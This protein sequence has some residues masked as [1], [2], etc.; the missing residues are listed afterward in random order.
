MQGF[1]DRKGPYL[2]VVEAWYGDF[3]YIHKV[4]GRHV[5]VDPDTGK[6]RR[7]C[8]ATEEVRAACQA[9]G[10]CPFVPKPAD[11]TKLDIGGAQLCGDDPTPYAAKSDTGL[12]VGYQCLTVTPD[13]WNELQSKPRP[14]AGERMRWMALRSGTTAAIRCDAALEQP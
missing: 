1:D 3:R 2:N 7:V 8:N 13:Q 11:G 9:K 4:M 12:Y 10:D 5:R 6:G 14:H